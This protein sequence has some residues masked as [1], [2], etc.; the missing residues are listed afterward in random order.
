MGHFEQDSEEPKSSARPRVGRTRVGAGAVALMLAA[1]FAACGSDSSSDT[2]TTAAAS[3]TTAAQTETTETTATTGT[4]ASAESNGVADK[5]ADEI[6]AAAIEAARGA[7]AVHVAGSANGVGLDLS[8]V[9]GEGASGSIEQGASRF[10][11]ITVGDE[12]FLRGSDEFYRGLGGESVVKLLSGKWLKVPAD[13]RGFESFAAITDMDTLLN[14]TLRPESS[15]A[16]EK[17]EVETVDGTEVIG[18]GGRR[19]TL[20]VATTGEPFPFKIASGD[21]TGSV[22]FDGWNEP[23]DLTAPTDAIDIDE[24]QRAGTQTTN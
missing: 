5:S 7:S 4:T 15:T 11:L 8:L 18:L 12:I 9:R 13:T 16:I 19:G 23:A 20:Y 17:G 10:E 6:L 14:E 2:T 1:S 21:D 3:G 24:L 22:T